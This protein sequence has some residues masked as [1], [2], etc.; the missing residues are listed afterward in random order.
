[1]AKVARPK[2]VRSGRSKNSCVR[3]PMRQISHHMP[4]ASLEFARKRTM[5]NSEARLPRT[6]K[7]QRSQAHRGF[8][9]NGA[10]DKGAQQRIPIAWH[11]SDT[12]SASVSSP[13]RARQSWCVADRAKAPKMAW[14][15]SAPNVAA[16][17][18][19]R[20]RRA[21]LSKCDEK[22]LKYNTPFH[23]CMAGQ[24]IWNLPQIPAASLRKDSM[25]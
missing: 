13:P 25:A 14:R 23:G 20:R 10:I 24:S 5:I 7:D 12:E 19:R 3:I 9:A 18:R 15:S 1:M 4:S 16:R 22:K 6:S 21:A 17:T 2:A 8:V 11:S